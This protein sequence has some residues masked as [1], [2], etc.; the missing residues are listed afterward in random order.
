M[1]I[2]KKCPWDMG[3]VLESSGII[4]L[5]GKNMEIILAKGVIIGT[6]TIML[7]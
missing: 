2:L 7:S 1:L 3:N 5:K 6:G 4:S